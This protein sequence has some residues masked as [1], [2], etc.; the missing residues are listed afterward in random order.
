MFPLSCLVHQPSGGLEGGAGFYI[1]YGESDAD[2]ANEIVQRALSED[3]RSFA[4]HRGV[5]ASDLINF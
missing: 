3:P 5:P 2:L 4:S 1:P